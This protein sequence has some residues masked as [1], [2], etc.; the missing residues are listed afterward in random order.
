MNTA[1]RAANGL[2]SVACLMV[3]FGLVGLF[4]Y[5]VCIQQPP[6]MTTESYSPASHVVAPGSI[7]YFETPIAPAEG[8]AAMAF[9]GDLMQGGERKY[10]LASPDSI[11]REELQDAQETTV[12]SAKPE[13]PL[14]ALFVPSYVRPGDYEYHV[15]VTYRLNPFKT[16]TVD[17]PPIQITVE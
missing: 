8:V 3:A 4:V 10:S 16:R 6:Q 13:H 7:V 14:Y 9:R 5:W 15:T 11:P 17:L 2:W 12:L 1:T